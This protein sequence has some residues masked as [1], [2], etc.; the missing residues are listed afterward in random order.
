MD[1]IAGLPNAYSS[2]W[3][4]AGAPKQSC[5]NE[6]IYFIGFIFKIL[7]WALSSKGILRAKFIM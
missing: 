6:C 7:R 1:D 3:L 4:I 5:A 2:A